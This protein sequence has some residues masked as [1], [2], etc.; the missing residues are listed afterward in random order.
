MNILTQSKLNELLTSGILVAD[1][2][3][4]AGYIRI[5]AV[6]RILKAM[7]SQI[8]R[9]LDSKYNALIEKMLKSINIV[10]SGKE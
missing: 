3:T 4:P 2:N 9:E 6:N 1:E 8:I 5:E 10:G 7:R